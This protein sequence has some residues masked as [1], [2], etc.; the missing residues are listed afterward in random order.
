MRNN[1]RILRIQNAKFSGHCFYMNTNIWRDFQICISVPLHYFKV[2]DK[3]CICI[4][5]VTHFPSTIKFLLQNQ[6]FYFSYKFVYSIYHLFKVAIKLKIALFFFL[7]PCI[8]PLTRENFRRDYSINITN[9]TFIEVFMKSQRMLIS[10]LM[11]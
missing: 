10:S 9:F 4:F 6:T 8:W 5:R 11:S 1:W 7:C 2:I 3:T